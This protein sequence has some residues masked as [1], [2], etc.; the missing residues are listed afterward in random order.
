M[1]IQDHLDILWK[2]SERIKFDP[3]VKLLFISD[4]HWGRGKDDKADD[5][6]NRSPI[7]YALLSWADRNGYALIILGDWLEL[8]END[9][10]D[11]IL[12]AYP[13]LWELIQKFR[14]EKHLWIVEGNHD[15]GLGYP[16]TY[17]LLLNGEEYFLVHGHQVD[18]WN[19]GIMWYV[20]KWFVRH[21]WRGL[22]YIGLHD[23]TASDEKRHA[24]SEKLLT[25]WAETNKIKTI[26]GHTHR[27]CMEGYYLNDGAFV[28]NSYAY[29]LYDKQN[30]MVLSVDKIP[31]S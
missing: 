21:I 31:S 10:K 13:A 15:K 12:V 26:S 30:G 17:V 16:E 19:S 8:Y 1:K 7:L 25:E 23:P 27:P 4:T 3:L 20:S 9:K 5:F 28:G 18:F 14:I 2:T 24:L 29:I 22:Q 6:Y 11:E